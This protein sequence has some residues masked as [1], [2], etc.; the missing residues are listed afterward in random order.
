[1]NHRHIRIV[2]FILALFF[3]GVSN[4]ALFAAETY[5]LDP[6]HTFVMFRVKY[7]GVGY[8]YGRFNR[9]AGKFVLDF[10]FVMRLS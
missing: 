8:A 2:V 3:L 5:N 7:L 6:A 9:P 10:F 1:M 4:N